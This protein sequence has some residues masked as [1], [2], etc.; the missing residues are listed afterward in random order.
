MKTLKEVI[1]LLRQHN[2]NPVKAIGKGSEQKSKLAALYHGIANGIYNSD[3]EAA[4]ALYGADSETSAYRKLKFNLLDRMLDHV[5]DIDVTQTHYS[6]YQKAYYESHKQWATIRYLIGQNAN[7]AALILAQR[8]LRQSEKFDF[9]LL[10]MDIA[11]YLRVQYGLRESN[12]KKFRETNRLY[13]KYHHL[14]TIECKAEEYYA[15]LVVKTVNN[16][17]VN[18]EVHSMA[19]EYYEAM[20]VEMQQFQTY[21]LQMYGYMIGIMYF[22]LSHDVKNTL[23][24][25]KDAIS[26]FKS[27]PYEP[28]VPLQIFYYQELMSHV[29]LNDFEK[30]GKSLDTCLTLHEEGTF[31]WFKFKELN[32]ILLL[33]TA[34]YEEAGQLLLKVLAHP[35]F[36]FL[37]DNARELWRIYES[38]IS[39][40]DV[41]GMIT[42]K[43]PNRFRLGKF[44]NEVPIFSRDKAGMNIAIQVIKF[45]FVLQEKNYNRVFDEVEGLEQYSYRHLRDKN[46]Q[47]SYLFLKMLLQIP[48]C[49]F[50]ISRIQLKAAPLMEQLQKIPL[51]FANQTYEIEVVPYEQLWAFALESISRNKAGLTGNNGS[52]HKLN[53]KRL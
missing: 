16:R 49:D 43:G 4:F 19:R 48:A 14:Y 42:K 27:R 25:C 6:D 28:R 21:K 5:L 30:A 31:N 33:R 10:S 46:T 22:S 1:V 12:D 24:V 26:F 11:S 3:E 23:Q 41:L 44:M 40:L 20:Q 53:E 37:P 7:T 17:T 47:R 32:L 8:L 50:D 51:Q 29:Q 9:T 2:I 15:A 39:Y 18:E 45:L 35:R 38:Y 52:V 34:S 36:E 13:E